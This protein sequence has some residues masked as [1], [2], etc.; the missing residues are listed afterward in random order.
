[1]TVYEG[2]NIQYTYIAI[3]CEVFM[4]GQDI[5]SRFS[6][7]SYDGIRTGGKRCNLQL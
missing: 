5:A 1:M 3:C 4:V 7:C 2:T 6:D